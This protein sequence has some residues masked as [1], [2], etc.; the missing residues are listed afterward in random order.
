MKI[1]AVNNYRFNSPV[2]QNEKRNPSFKSDYEVD[3]SSAY[4]RSQVITLGMLMNNFWVNNARYTFQQMRYSGVYGPVTVHVKDLRDSIFEK[5]M[6][7]NN[8]SY[9]KVESNVKYY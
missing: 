6:Q 2:K 8:I 3:M 5:I 7:N 9:K 4:S 1:N